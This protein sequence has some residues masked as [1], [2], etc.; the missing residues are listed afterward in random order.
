M[1]FAAG[2][3]LPTVSK[4]GKSEKG[5]VPTIFTDDL[6]TTSNE[7]AKENFDYHLIVVGGGSG[8]LAAAKE[9]AK[10]GLKTA[11]FDYVKPLPIGTTWGL[12]GTCV[13]VGWPKKLV[14]QA[15]L[16][17]EML[18]DAHKFGW[19]NSDKK[20]KHSWERLVE[21]IQHQ[22]KCLNSDLQSQIRRKG[23]DY[24]NELVQFTGPNTIVAT[25]KNGETREVT[26]SM[27][28]LAVGGRP[29]YPKI[30]GAREHSITSD[31][32]F[33]LSYNRGQKLLVG[34]SYISLELA[35]VLHRIGLDVT[36]MVRSILL[37]GVVRKPTS[38]DLKIGAI[39]LRAARFSLK[40]STRR[41]IQA[42]F[43]LLAGYA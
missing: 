14:H 4:V 29:R 8:G 25:E 11:V 36:V 23:V 39:G 24:F 18:K 28:V 38:T 21:N 9:A 6:T 16:L 41:P 30:P 33:S 22:V 31:N 34:A 40:R 42:V 1:P 10:F 5:S 17:G 12:G 3:L 27:F 37:R 32:I 43:R 15:A 20:P 19:E 2:I 13:N 7:L 35:G 26:S